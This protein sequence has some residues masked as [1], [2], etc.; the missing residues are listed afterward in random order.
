MM[1]RGL[2]AV[3]VLMGAAGAAHAQMPGVQAGAGV[4]LQS[5]SFAAPDD[6]GIDRISLLTV[7]L[8]AQAQ[9]LRSLE[10]HIGTAFARGSMERPGAG[11]ATLSGLT[12]TQ[13]RLT[14]ATP[15]DRVRLTAIGV[16]PTGQ[17]ELTAAEMDLAGVIAADLLPFAIANW[18]TGGGVGLSAAAAVPLGP[19]TSFGISGGYV[20]ARRFEPLADARFAYRPGN[21]LHVRGAVDH[22]FG[23]S[24]KAS[25]QVSWQQFGTD[26]AAGANLYQAGDR[27][28]VVGSYAFAAGPR[29][30]GIAFAGYLRRG[31]GQYTDVVRVIPVQDL[32][33]GGLGMRLPAGGLVLTPLADVRVV[34]REDGRDQGYV[35][36]A[37]TGLEIPLGGPLVLVPNVRGR[38]GNLSVATDVESGFTGFEVGAV[39][40]MRGV[41]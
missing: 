27:L 23:T 17:T 15:R 33:Y 34:G 37:G 35:V 39:I 16:L 25:V 12:D 30:S 24:G 7:P 26:E 36:S 6:A 2:I 20:V 19:A 13:V 41:R 31:E 10:L 3:G 5:Y 14:F 11:E 28:Q 18:G 8:S 29:S 21:Q 22:S 9:L 4:T 32:V 40:R 38:F 1:T